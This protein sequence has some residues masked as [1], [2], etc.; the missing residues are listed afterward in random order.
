MAALSTSGLS[1]ACA[2]AQGTEDAKDSAAHT[3]LASEDFE[4]VEL[5]AAVAEAVRTFNAEAARFLVPRLC[6]DHTWLTQSPVHDQAANP[7]S[8]YEGGVSPPR[9]ENLQSCCPESLQL[10]I[11]RSCMTAV[12]KISHAHFAPH[13][14]AGQH[15]QQVAV[16]SRRRGG[17]ADAGSASPYEVLPPAVHGRLNRMPAPQES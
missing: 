11:V 7:P 1:D 3:R 9:C 2:C 16:S 13:R 17:Y 12:A 6:L 5:A 4:H 15:G 10:T 14:L 8:P